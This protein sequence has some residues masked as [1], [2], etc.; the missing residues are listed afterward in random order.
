MSDEVVETSA[1]LFRN[2]EVPFSAKTSDAIVK[3]VRK[4]RIKKVIA[5]KPQRKAGIYVILQEC[6]VGVEPTDENP[7]G[8]LPVWREVG[9][10]A[11]SDL[12]IKEATGL[13]YGQPSTVFMVSRVLSTLVSQSITTTKLVRG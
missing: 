7:D 8:K 6:Y 13:A 9:T 11:T 5:V 3:R 10:H 4:P 1:P 2:G 12:A